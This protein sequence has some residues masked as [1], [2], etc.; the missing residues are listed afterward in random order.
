MLVARESYLIR[1]ESPDAKGVD[2]KFASLLHILNG[3]E[4]FLLD[5]EGNIKGSN[6][7]AVNVTGYEEYEILGKHIS[8]FYRPEEGDKSTAD[9]E[10]AFRLGSLVVTGLRL[11]KRG[12]NFWA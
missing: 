1:E 12:V 10:K 5:R 6:L 2:H 9:L 3:E 7:E 8:I 11:K 4:E